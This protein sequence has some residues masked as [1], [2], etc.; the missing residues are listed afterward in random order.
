L[1][2]GA[3][4]RESGIA[5]RFGAKEGDSDLEAAAGIQSPASRSDQQPKETHR[6][7]RKTTALAAGL[8]FGAT[9]ICAAGDEYMTIGD[10]APAIDIAHWVKG[11]KI[12]GFESG[13]VYVL[14]FWA[15]WCGPCVASM[16]HLSELQEKYRDYDVTFVGVSDEP[17]QTVVEFLFRT[18]KKDGKIHNDRTHYTLTCDP[19]E[20]VKNAYF[21]AAGQNGIPCAFIIGK[22]THVEWIGHP[23]KIDEALDGVVRDSW[24]RDAFRA[25]WEK[26]ES[27]KREMMA[28][29][30]KLGEAMADEDYDAAVAIMDGMIA[31]NPDS[32]NL[33]VQKLNILLAHPGGEKKAYGLAHE[34]AESNWDD[35]QMLNMI[36][37]TIVDD[38]RVKHRNFDF[39]LKAALRANELTE[40]KDPAILDTVARAY[41]ESGNL[42]KAIKWQTK[43]VESSAG[44]PYEEDLKKA[45]MKYAAEQDG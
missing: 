44:T 42:H 15:T 17:L 19:D 12:D 7:I 9:A 28:M 33:K 29:R 26:S 39:A 35:A 6:M 2:P 24:D 31:D 25:K 41:Y 5:H 14:E 21:K 1:C 38:K 32:V 40:D 16:P 8:A 34:L 11:D 27:Q 37:W 3:A 10:E 45:L 4:R 20:S 23:M 36:A 30:Q 22:D 43:A 18:Y 13:K